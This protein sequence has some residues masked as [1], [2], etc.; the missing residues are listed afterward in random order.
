MV[1]PSLYHI[2]PISLERETT[3]TINMANRKIS[4]ATGLANR[5]VSFLPEA[6]K[7]PESYLDARLTGHTLV[8]DWELLADVAGGSQRP[9]LDEVV[10]RAGSTSSREW[11]DLL[12]RFERM[13]RSKHCGRNYRTSKSSS[14]SNKPNAPA[15]SPNTPSLDGSYP[16]CFSARSSSSPASS[17][18]SAISRIDFEDPC[19]AVESA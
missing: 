17:T 19:F 5:T 16:R 18:A 6:A 4:D 2:D 7:R 3:T 13:L 9:C 15:H 8:I 1:V 12:N 14:Q 11:R 10:C